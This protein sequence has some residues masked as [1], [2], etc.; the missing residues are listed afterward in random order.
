M[1][2]NESALVDATHEAPSSDMDKSRLQ[3][4]GVLAILLFVETGIWDS[5][6]DVLRDLKAGKVYLNNKQLTSTQRRVTMDDVQ[7]GKYLV[8]SK[9]QRVY[10]VLHCK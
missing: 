2:E 10:H 4:V 3:G 1:F 9:K 8:V 6:S 5:S 7:Y